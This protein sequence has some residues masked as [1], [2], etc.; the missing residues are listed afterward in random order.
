MKLL[1]PTKGVSARQ[2]SD[3]LQEK[4]KPIVIPVII[5]LIASNIDAS[6]SVEI[7][8]IL[9]ASSESVAFRIPGAF[10]LSSNHPKCLEMIFS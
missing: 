4:K 3:S 5:A 7:P 2:T 8:F 10:S 1:N 6:P 9:Y